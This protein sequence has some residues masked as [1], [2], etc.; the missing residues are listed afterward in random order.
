MTSNKNKPVQKYEHHMTRKEREREELK[1]FLW[2]FLCAAEI[3]GAC[4][5]APFFL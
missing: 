3:F 1:L 2:S 5:L 4:M